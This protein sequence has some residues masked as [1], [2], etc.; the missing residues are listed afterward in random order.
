VSNDS[1]S[2]EPACSIQHQN[3]AIFRAVEN[4]R[5]MV[6]ATTAGLTCVI[7]PNG[8]TIAKLELFKP[9]YLITDV[10]VYTGRTTLY[11]RFGDWFEKLLLIITIP[12]MAAALAVQLMRLVRRRKTAEDESEKVSGSRRQRSVKTK[13]RK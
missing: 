7:D 5:S 10:P 3:M 12:L 4:R 8:K 1:W 6:R 2:P 11:T 9:G 13:R